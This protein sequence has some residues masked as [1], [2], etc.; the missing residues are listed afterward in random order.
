M[1]KRK[2]FF[3]SILE[4]ICESQSKRRKKEDEETIVTFNTTSSPNVKKHLI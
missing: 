4:N 1:K 2:I 3:E